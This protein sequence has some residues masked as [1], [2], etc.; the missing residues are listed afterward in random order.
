MVK[1]LPFQVQS[2]D[3]TVVQASPT[4]STILTGAATADYHLNTKDPLTSA[5]TFKDFFYGQG[6]NSI[7]KFLVEF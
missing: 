7:E 2:A 3:G 5:R 1:H 4:P 6:P